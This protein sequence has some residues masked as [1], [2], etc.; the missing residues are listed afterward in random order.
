MRQAGVALGALEYRPG[1]IERSYDLE[2]MMLGA[3]G[4]DGVSAFLRSIGSDRTHPLLDGWLEKL[5]AY[6]TDVAGFADYYAALDQ[7]RA[8][9]HASMKEFDAILSPVSSSAALLHGT[10]MEEET[11]KGFSYTMTHNLT[12]WP[13]GV[14]RCGSTSSGLPIGVQ[15][16]AAP[17]REDIVLAVARRLEE[18]FGG[19][20]CPEAY[21][22]HDCRGSTHQR[23]P[24]SYGGDSAAPPGLLE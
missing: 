1:G 15:I 24:D 16:A 5:E 6:R 20:Q 10:S 9:M 14:A 21:P 4:G 8:S 11:F 3:D 17:W 13:A 18:I 19:W 22:L 2:M 23:N 7:F 12:G